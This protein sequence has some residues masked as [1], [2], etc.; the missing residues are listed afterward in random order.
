[1]NQT[2]ILSYAANF[3]IANRDAE[4]DDGV[5]NVPTVAEIKAAFLSM[6]INPDKD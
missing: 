3:L 2:Q 6:G 1:M 5:E 4:E